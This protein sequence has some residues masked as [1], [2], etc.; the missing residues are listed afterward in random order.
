MGQVGGT[1][2]NLLGER[3]QLGAQGGAFGV[4]G[5]KL[6]LG[7]GG[8]PLGGGHGG[9]DGVQQDLVLL[10]LAGQAEDLVLLLAKLPAGRLAFKGGF[11]RGA[12]GFAE[13]AV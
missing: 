13:L 3:V 12:D 4:A 8:L 7:G 5:I 1:G 2:G 11:L 9:G 6:G 10:L